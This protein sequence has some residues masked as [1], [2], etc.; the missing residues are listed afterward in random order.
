MQIPATSTE[1]VYIPVTGPPGVDPTASAVDVAF[2][3]EQA[4]EPLSTDWKAATWATDPSSGK[5][6][7]RLLVTAGDYPAGSYMAYVRLHASPELPV[8]ESGRVRV[9]N[10]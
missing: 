7:A 5:P 10:P 4:G 6:A 1:Y 8:M 9:G 3:G 2:V